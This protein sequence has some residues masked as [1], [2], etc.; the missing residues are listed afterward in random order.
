MIKPSVIYK[1][2]FQRRL[3]II[4]EVTLSRLLRRYHFPQDNDMGDGSAPERPIADS[5]CSIMN[6]KNCGTLL[7]GH[8]AAFGG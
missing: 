1:V 8:L 5:G 2:S 3:K 6:V 4:E 7:I